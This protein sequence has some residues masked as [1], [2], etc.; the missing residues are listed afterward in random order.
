MLGG[1]CVR[2]SVSIHT[3]PPPPPPPPNPPPPPLPIYPKKEGNG[4]WGGGALGSGAAAG[5]GGAACWPSFSLT[6]ISLFVSLFFFKFYSVVLILN[7]KCLSLC[8]KFGLIGCVQLCLCAICSNL[9][10]I[11]CRLINI[12]KNESYT[13][14]Q[15]G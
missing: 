5:G 7:V 14:I 13:N 8:F 6:C 9:N 4:P 11:Q 12:Y 10:T 1:V 3:L 2:P 15:K